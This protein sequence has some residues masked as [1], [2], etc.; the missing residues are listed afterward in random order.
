MKPFQKSA[1]ASLALWA[2]SSASAITV[3]I[4]GGNAAGNA[5]ITSFLNAN[6]SNV[7]EVRSGDFANF[8]STATQ[9]ALN[10][11]G[12]S[13]AAD[14][15]IFGR[16]TTSSAYQ[17]VAAGYN[18]LTI[19]VVSLTSFVTRSTGNRLG[20]TSG[21]ILN[22]NSTGTA[23]AEATLT[24]AGALLF[25]GVAGGTLDLHESEGSTFNAAGTGSVGE[26]EILATI[27]NT[28]G[29]TAILAARW[30]AGDLSGTGDVLG[31]DR[32]LFNLDPDVPGA[33]PD[34]TFAS[35][36]TT[37]EAALITALEDIS[38]LTAVPEPSSLL[39]CSLGALGLLRR[40]RH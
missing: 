32:L 14:L 6:F 13:A 7:T 38:D 35:L 39:L 17:N 15:V 27:E 10:G 25:G 1:I 33:T 37:G 26:G 28:A 12:T 19:P 34:S 29:G 30:N 18:G 31:G 4:S 3:V 16:Q 36:T 23:G 5:E 21:N 11:T 22:Q 24:A 9:E 40:Q 20:W 2:T 8:T